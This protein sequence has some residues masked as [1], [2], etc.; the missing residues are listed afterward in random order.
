M[1]VSVR[2]GGARGQHGRGEEYWVVQAV[3]V[4]PE[5]QV[6]VVLVVVVLIDVCLVLQE[7]S[8]SRIV[9]AVEYC[10]GI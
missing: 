4:C 1:E 3:V 8:G 9:G 6:A 5:V 2:E 10:K 7:G